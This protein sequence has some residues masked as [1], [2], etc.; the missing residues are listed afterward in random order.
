MLKSFNRFLKARIVEHFG[1]QYEFARFLDI[2]ASTV[3]YVI[4]G[5]WNLTD[6]DMIVWAE[7]LE[8]DVDELFG[9]PVLAG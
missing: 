9:E 4:S 5:R 7:A 1:T 3:S 6:D 8:C 2:P